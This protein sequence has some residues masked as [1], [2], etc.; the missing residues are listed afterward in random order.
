MAEFKDICRRNGLPPDYSS[1]HSLR[2]GGVTH[3][4]A[5]GVTEDDRRDRG[6]YAAVSQVMNTTYDYAT[7]LRPL[8]SNG[9]EGGHE[10]T[11]IDVKRLIPTRR[12]SL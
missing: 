1:A 5:Q 6:N 9:L 10:P 7:E 8:A 3:M 4:R 2:K 12:R 11:L